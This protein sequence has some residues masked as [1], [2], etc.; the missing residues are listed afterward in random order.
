MST[1]TELEKRVQAL[2]ASVQELKA[3]LSGPE[4]PARSWSDLFG[5]YKDD[6]AFAEATRLG[7]EYREK[8]NRESL[9]EL[10]RAG[11]KGGSGKKGAK[12]RKPAARG[13]N[14]RT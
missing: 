5:K 1:I 12:K 13:A 2:E 3:Q 11:K 8:Q 7:R 10:D 14:G 9:A 4:Q 6:P